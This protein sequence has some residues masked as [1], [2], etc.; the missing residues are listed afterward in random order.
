MQSLGC[1]LYELAYGLS[2]FEKGY[3]HHGASIKLSVL[4]GKY[5]FPTTTRYT[6]GRRVDWVSTKTKLLF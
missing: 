5:T 1:T 4:N 3:T 6:L 2:P